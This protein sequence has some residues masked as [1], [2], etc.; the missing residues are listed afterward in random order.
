[1]A[2][3]ASADPAEFSYLLAALERAE[4]TDTFTG[5]GPF[6]VFAPTDAAFQA[7]GFPDIASVEAADPNTLAAILTHHVVKLT[8]EYSALTLP[9]GK[10]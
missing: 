1:M 8:P 10:W 7:A 5:D 2:A 3:S 4:L 6:T 9:M